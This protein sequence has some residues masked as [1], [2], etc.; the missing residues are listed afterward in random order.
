M[1]QH[2]SRQGL[3]RAYSHLTRLFL[4]PIALLALSCFPV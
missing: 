1:A 3:S 4:P 2:S